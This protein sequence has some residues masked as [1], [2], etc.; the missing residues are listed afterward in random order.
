MVV[1]TTSPGVPCIKTYAPRVFRV[2]RCPHP[3]C[4]RGLLLAFPRSPSSGIIGI[5]SVPSSAASGTFKIAGNLPVHRLGYG[6]MRLV[7]DGAWGE[8]DNPEDARLVLRRAV[9]LG[10]TLL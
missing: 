9:D 2:P 4:R 8:P 5:M 1:I 10:V 6:T 3:A 7:G